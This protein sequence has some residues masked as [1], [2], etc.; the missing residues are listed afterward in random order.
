MSKKKSKIEKG[1]KK[2]EIEVTI[3]KKKKEIKVPLPPEEIKE[4]KPKEKEE[5]L[6]VPPE[7]PKSFLDKWKE[8][9]EEKKNIKKLKQ[10][11]KE[12]KK[13]EEIK[14]EIKEES[15]PQEEKKEEPTLEEEEPLP[16]SE[17]ETPKK[18]LIGQL[19]E[20]RE[21]LDII[22][23]K[24]KQEKKLKK[25]KF[26]IPF[27]VKSQLKKLAMKNKVQV[28]LLQRTR[29][30][31]PVIGEIRDGMLIVGKDQIYNGSVD[32]TWLWNGKYPTHLV[33]EWDLQPLTPE[34]IEE[35]KA[36][37]TMSSSELHSYCIKFGRLAVPG[38]II[39]RAIEAK[40]NQMLGAKANVK[41]IILVIVGTIIACAILFSGG[42]V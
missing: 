34:G 17:E 26:K 32:S 16:T 13:P 2:D 9:I 19:K 8:K 18:G 6:D 27:K 35:M 10:L 28:M 33:P 30:I 36:T 21:S 37:S 24:K 14:E 25:K 20:I 31:K 7:K 11:E 1:K 40:Q 39:I 12:L 42:F 4:K 15:K 23:D 5:E 41:T 22:S 29:N 3:K 38:K